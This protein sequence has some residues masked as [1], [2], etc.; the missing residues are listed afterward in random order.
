[1]IDFCRIENHHILHQYV[2]KNHDEDIKC[3]ASKTHR[4]NWF[5]IF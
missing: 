3:I 2:G 4:K 1:M 5:T